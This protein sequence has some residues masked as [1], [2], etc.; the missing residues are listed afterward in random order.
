M[1]FMLA[2]SLHY[3]NR[4]IIYS[5]AY[6]MCTCVIV[7]QIPLQ[8]IFR[9]QQQVE[10]N[11]RIGCKAGK[12]RGWLTRL[13]EVD[14]SVCCTR[15]SRLQR[16]LGVWDAVIGASLSEPH[17]SR[18]RLCM[19]RCMDRLT[20]YVSYNSFNAQAIPPFNNFLHV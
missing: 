14:I 18:N 6:T 16:H 7:G 3:I 4:S 20:V 2:S 17:T 11:T 1:G 13:G 15:L 19:S 12:K 5:L 10:N 8:I 9:T